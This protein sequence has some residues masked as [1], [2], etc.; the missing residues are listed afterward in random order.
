MFDGCP[1]TA[2]GGAPNAHIAMYKVCTAYG[3][4]ADSD[5]L[6]GFDRAVADGV[7]VLSVSLGIDSFDLETDAVA[8]GSFH[9]LTKNV[10]VVAAGGNEGPSLV[11]VENTAPWLLT[12]AA[13]SV[14]RDFATTLE[15][16][17]GEELV[18]KVRS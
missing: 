12:V 11:S 7:D 16:G 4:C 5:I 18:D 6:A 2:S 13:S 1:G 3:A 15:L 8:I 17:N 9:A 14:P 10:L